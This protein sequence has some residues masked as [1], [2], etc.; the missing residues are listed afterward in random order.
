LPLMLAT[1]PFLITMSLAAKK[2]QS[3]Y[4]KL[5]I[6]TCKPNSQE[7]SLTDIATAILSALQRRHFI[8]D[9]ITRES[10][11]ISTRSDGTYRVLLDD[12]EPEQSTHFINCVK[13]ALLPITNQPF[14]IPKYEYFVGEVE[15]EVQ[16]EEKEKRFFRAYLAGKADP[17]IAAYYP[18]PGLLA[19]SEK[20]REAYE[21]AWNKYVSPGFIVATETKPEL[22]NRYF[23]MG[24]SLAQRL[25][26]E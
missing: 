7:S 10:I 25:L 5:Q 9:T 3:L 13:E 1:I 11:K 23:R 22:L 26:W 8:P 17:R 20:G 14:L 4:N 18:V 15:G 12:V 19:R 2:Y 24:P 21:A 6:E 16:G